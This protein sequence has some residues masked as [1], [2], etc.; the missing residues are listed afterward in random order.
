MTERPRLAIIC[1]HPIQYY[2]PMFKLMARSVE[3]KVF[4]TMG[5][6]P[7]YDRGFQKKFHWDI[8]MLEGYDHQFLYNKAAR[9]GTHHFF[10]IVNPGAITA[11]DHFAPHYILIYGWANY[12]HLKIMYHYKGKTPILFRGDS[13][14]LKPRNLFFELIKDRV[15]RHIYQQIDIAVF[16]GSNNKA[17]F[18]KYKVPDRRLVFAP[19]AIDNKRFS[20]K[21]PLTKIRETLNI[22]PEKTLILFTGK[23]IPIKNPRLLLKA[24]SA[25]DRPDIHLLIVGDGPQGG[26]LKKKYKQSN[27]HYMPFQNQARMP[28]IY[29]ACDLFCMPS[30][31]ESWGMAVNE[32]MAAGKAILTSD[33]TG[34]AADLIKPENG[35][36]FKSSNPSDLKEKLMTMT[37]DKQKL[38]EMGQAS[39]KI[40]QVWDFENQIKGILH[41]ISS[42]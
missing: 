41:A 10:G 19:H 14:S 22:S 13:T 2:T 9:P 39:Q 12:S 34:A 28:A 7:E 18:S 4:F 42:I 3:L 37:R 33:Q 23:L 32:A 11:I 40:I 8:P 5:Q 38:L 29:Q 36:T 27:I 20:R 25:L 21:N 26:E 15:L 35:M 16:T 31:S 30:I 1:T 6:I 24:F 17:Y